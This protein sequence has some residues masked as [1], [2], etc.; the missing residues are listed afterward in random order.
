MKIMIVGAG[1]IGGYI[2]G[3]LC[4]KNSDIT[5]VARGAQLAAILEKGLTVIDG[6]MRFTVHPALCTDKPSE[7]GVQDAILICTKGYGLK[8]ALDQIRPCVGPDTLLIP[9]LNG[10]NTH[11]RIAAQLNTGVALDGCIYIFSRIVAPGTIQKDG[12]LN[13]ICMGIPGKSAAESP[14]MLTALRD[15]LTQSGVPAEIPDDIV[16]EMWIKWTFICGNAQATS[17]YNVTI[18]QLRDDPEKWQFLTVLLDEI[19]LVA[20]AEGVHLPEDT[21]ERNLAA[22]RG[23]PYEAASSLSRDL[24]EPGKPTELD[25]F[26][27]ELCRMADKH[28]I[29]VPNNRRVLERFADRI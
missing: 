14:A 19:L 9:L 28:G 27:G 25:L 16:R 12:P 23:M 20:R 11:K 29:D 15:M 24:N 17:Y 8:E 10:V 26:A 22:L 1:G 3:M 13:R 18:G 5:L 2:A 4:R 21:K 6:D 7:A